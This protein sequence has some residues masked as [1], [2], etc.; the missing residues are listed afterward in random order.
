VAY[1][2][3]SP[4]SRMARLH[5]E[6]TA[7]GHCYLLLAFIGRQVTALLLAYPFLHSSF[8]GALSIPQHAGSDGGDT[9]RRS[10]GSSFLPPSVLTA[11]TAWRSSPF[12]APFLP[13]RSV[14]SGS[15]PAIRL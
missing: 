14:A 1:G 15:G 12:S 8:Y 4:I 6:R 11:L 3:F 5:G 7:G 10:N 9:Y 13:V 2:F